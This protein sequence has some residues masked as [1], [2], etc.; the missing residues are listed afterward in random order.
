MTEA[1]SVTA[2]T[3]PAPPEDPGVRCVVCLSE[4]GGKQINAPRPGKNCP[5]CGARGSIA[6]REW[7][8]CPTCG[9]ESPVPPPTLL[10][11]EALSDGV[12]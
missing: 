9:H 4:W 8:R 2:T 12:T 3:R 1:T 11:L 7:K 6:V 5:S 10:E